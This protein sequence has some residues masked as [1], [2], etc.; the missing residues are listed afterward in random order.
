[1]VIAAVTSASTTEVRA[2]S[3]L[4][5]PG[6]FGMP[7]APG[8][9]YVGLFVEDDFNQVIRP[10]TLRRFT[11]PQEGTPVCSS[12]TDQLCAGATMHMHAILP[13]C[14]GN[15]QTDCIESVA[16]RN[17]SSELLPGQF[18]RYFPETASSNFVG[19]PS[20]RIPNG[21]SPSIWN[22]S[23]APHA[24]GTS[25]MAL[26]TVDGSIDVSR[27][28]FSGFYP[29]LQVALFPVKMTAGQFEPWI[30]DS[31]GVSTTSQDSYGNCAALSHG[32]CAARQDFPTA[33]KFAI[34]LKLSNAPVGWL[35]GRIFDPVVDYRHSSDS[36]TLTVEAK[37]A[38]VPTVALWARGSQVPTSMAPACGETQMCGSANGW[39]NP[40]SVDDWRQFYQD[41]AAWIRG[42]WSFRNGGGSSASSGTS[43]FS[44]ASVFHGLVTTNASSY[45]GGPPVYSSGDQTFTYG[46]GS[47]HF[48]ENGVVLSGTYSLV[49]RSSTAKCLYGIDSGSMSATVSVTEGSN[50]VQTNFVESVVDD[51]TWLRI[52]AS[53]F[54]FSRPDIKVKLTSTSSPSKGKVDVSPVAS[55]PTAIQ[56]QPAS[57]VSISSTKLV[58]ATNG[59][60]FEVAVSTK[61]GRTV[62]AKNLLK[63]SK[64]VVVAKVV[65]TSKTVCV[66]TRMSIKMLKLG[67]CRLAVVSKYKTKSATSRVSIRVT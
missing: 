57:P 48:D 3:I 29:S 13:R 27:R 40:N 19:D 33:L 51:G 39:N 23:G 25:Y 24:G 63:P 52:N 31:S 62:T 49:L 35:S 32:F 30:P 16:A 20:V 45:S 50:G 56:V 47:P 14:E 61:K 7:A 2:S 46:V 53:G 4:R 9:G 1:M 60:V 43:C 17:E 67:T 37:P 8:P 66:S 64:G 26:V 38:L 6:S 18:D 22:I 41:K 21:S 59:A 12:L 34:T 36:T 55:V 11:V 44:D 65:S 54:H 15:I 42:H 5:G 10:S 58:K 28:V